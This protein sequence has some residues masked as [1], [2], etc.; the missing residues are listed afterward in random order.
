VRRAT[1]E[2]PTLAEATRA[3]LTVL[4]RDPDGFF[5]LV[6]QGDIDWANHAGDVPRM[7][8]AVW[9][10]DRA[11]REAM[12]F[13]DRPGDALTWEDTLLIVTA[14]HAT[15]HLR[16]GPGRP[17]G[18]GMLPAVDGSGHPTDPSQL[19]LPPSRAG[20]WDH[21][22]E[23][24]TV[25]AAGAGAPLLAARAGRWYPGTRIVDQV[26]VWEAMAEFLGLRPPPG[27]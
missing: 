14:D 26:Q 23:L 15:N 7:I 20:S 25:A 19:V 3:A 10:L 5:L 8:G 11:V 9:D 1:L 16:L 21:T 17:L 13:V 18:R 2:N 6:E 24:V 12:A 22:N 27:R 4:S